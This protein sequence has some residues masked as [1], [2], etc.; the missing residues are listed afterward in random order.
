MCIDA[1]FD[2]NKVL[3]CQVGDLMA[4]QRFRTPEAVEY[5]VLSL[6]ADFDSHT[7]VANIM[8]GTVANINNSVKLGRDRQ[9]R[10]YAS[11]YLNQQP[12]PDAT[13]S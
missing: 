9:G 11:R 13:V 5:M 12:K 4:G 1:S 2:G 7:R 6:P 8:T 3:V 10:L